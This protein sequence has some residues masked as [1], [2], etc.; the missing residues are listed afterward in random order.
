MWD[1]VELEPTGGNIPVPVLQYVFL[2]NSED[3]RWEECPRLL[4]VT[5]FIGRVSKLAHTICSVQSST[6]S[7]L[8]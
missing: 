6:K 2:V 5:L 8:S 1:L 4:I 3:L 7:F